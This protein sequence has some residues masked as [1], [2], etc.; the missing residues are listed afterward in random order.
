MPVACAADSGVGGAVCLFELAPFDQLDDA[1]R[2][3]RDGAGLIC[4]DEIRCAGNGLVASAVGED[5]VG[6]DH[7]T[8]AAAHVD[9]IRQIATCVA[10]FVPILAEINMRAVTRRQRGW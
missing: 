6:A 10:Q 5:G 2:Y 4:P 9:A 7:V 3:V 8:A 1:L